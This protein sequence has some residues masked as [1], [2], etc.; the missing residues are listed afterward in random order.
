MAP[1]LNEE[2]VLPKF[3]NSLLDQTFK[4]FQ[5]IIVDGGSQD[6]SL[7]ILMEY[8]FK[9]ADLRIPLL[10]VV[11]ETR[12]LGYIRNVGGLCASAPIIVQCNTDNIFPSYFLEKLCE[13]YRDSQVV[14]VS[15]RV[16]PVEMD[17]VA[18]VGYQLYDLLRWFF[19]KLPFPLKKYRPSGNFCT[20][21]NKVW[22]E[23]GGFPEIPVN[24]DGLFG[25]RIERY[26]RAHDKRIVFCLDLFVGH[27]V[28]KFE[29][30]G[31]LNAL[32]FYFY[33]LGNFSP[34]LKKVL[35]PIEDY[36]AQIFIKKQVQRLTL[37]QVLIRFWMWL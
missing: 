32:M 5:I 2:N 13:L 14:S 18:H 12:N 34:L 28:K 21:T 7:Q 10:V 4:E 22:N 11:D 9:F 19:V 6:N 20:F 26:A 24:E 27:H 29:S 30:M 23:V 35:R 37:K 31:S 1:N 25:E 8:S 33:V 16:R 36:A 15:G 3:L 17:L